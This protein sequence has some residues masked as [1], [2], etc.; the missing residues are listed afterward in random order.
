MG[1]S[2]ASRRPA[3]LPACTLCA[4]GSA[5]FGGQ[6]DLGDGVACRDLRLAHRQVARL[7]AKGG[8]AG[9]GRRGNGQEGDALGARVRRQGQ[10][11][12]LRSAKGFTKG[13]VKRGSSTQRRADQPDDTRPLAGQGVR[14]S[15]G[16][17]IGDDGFAHLPRRRRP[18]H[19]G[20]AAAGGQRCDLGIR[21]AGRPGTGRSGL[22]P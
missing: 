22:F 13:H 11:D 6:G 12:D 5:A 15:C 14:P 18:G 1:L 8:A 20:D 9:V 4:S 17:G 16:I 2:V 19:E 3:K 7:Q 10:I 21:S